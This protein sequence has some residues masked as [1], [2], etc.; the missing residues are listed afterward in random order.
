MF[1]AYNCNGC[2]SAPIT[3]YKNN[4]VYQEITKEYECRD[5]TKD[6]RLYIDMRRSRGNSDE[7]EKLTRDD[8]GIN[9]IVTLKAVV[10]KK[11]D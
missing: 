6:D 8:S 1:I 7:L 5:N 9:L 3:Q 4:E 2:T 10:T 11:R